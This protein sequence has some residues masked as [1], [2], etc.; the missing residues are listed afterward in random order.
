MHA[1]FSLLALSCL[2][3]FSL[4]GCE[5]S[6][7][8]ESDEAHLAPQ[9]SAIV[10]STLIIRLGETGEA[11]QKRNPSGV[12]VN[13]QPAGVDFY[14]LD[15][16]RAPYASV[17]FVQGNHSFEFHHVNGVQTSEDR[18]AFKE[19]GFTEWTVH[20]LLDPAQELSH[21]EAEARI[22]KLLRAAMDAGWRQYVDGGDPRLRGQ[23]RLNLVLH[24]STWLGLDV[25]HEPSL[26]DRVKIPDRTPWKLCV[27]GAFM[28]LSFTRQ[29]L[30]TSDASKAVYLMTFNIKSKNEYLR[31][32]V[33]S[34]QLPKWREVLPA[35]L[36]QAAAQRAEE[37]RVLRERGIEID[38]GYVDPACARL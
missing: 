35:V 24:G 1:L 10:P 12:R 13:R 3:F 36:T 32:G 21:T 23:D 19:E 15:W 26:Q 14:G 8:V 4:I 18:E 16:D 11:F 22:H 9:E 7:S 28:E 30:P 31:A 6:Q 2:V 29:A 37:E 17:R 33:E 34:D 20:A 5:Q 27:E 38:E 25:R